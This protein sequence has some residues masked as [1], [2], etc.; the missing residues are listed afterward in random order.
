VYAYCTEYGCEWNR[1][2]TC[3]VFALYN[4]DG[5]LTQTVTH[6]KSIIAPYTTYYTMSV[7]YPVYATSW[8]SLGSADVIINFASNHGESDLRINFMGWDY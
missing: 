8:V 4:F 2:G 1:Y 6:T 5:R 3:T 7:K